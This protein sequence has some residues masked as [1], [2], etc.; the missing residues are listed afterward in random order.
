[1]YINFKALYARL[2]AMKITVS[3]TTLLRKLNEY[4]CKYDQDVLIEKDVISKHLMKVISHKEKVNN[5]EWPETNQSTGQPQPERR[6]LVNDVVS[7]TVSSESVAS[8]PAIAVNGCGIHF[9]IDNIDF[10]QEVKGMT[11]E[12]QNKDFHWTNHNCIKNRI[13]GAYLQYI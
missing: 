4:G 6:S 3:N 10:R 9:V 8:M 13:S 2:C 5:V 7:S 11:A 1:V 12:N